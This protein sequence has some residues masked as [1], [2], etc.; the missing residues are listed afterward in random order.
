MKHTDGEEEWIEIH[1]IEYDDNGEPIDVREPNL[2][3]TYEEVQN[4]YDLMGEA[5][6]SDVVDYNEVMAKIRQKILIEREE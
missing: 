3:G 4:N 1:E 5:F 6:M 2:S